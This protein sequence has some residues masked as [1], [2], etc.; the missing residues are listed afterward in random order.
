MDEPLKD[1]DAEL[2]EI[3][4]MDDP[5]LP[6]SKKKGDDDLGVEEDEDIDALA[7]LEDMDDEEEKDLW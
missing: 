5:L 4:E 2:E 7:D 6:I 1:D 3:D